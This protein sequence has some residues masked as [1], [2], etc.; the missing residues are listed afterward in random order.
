MSTAPCRPILVVD[1]EEVV[2]ELLTRAFG[3]KGLRV[4]AVT[5]GAQAISLLSTE[6]FAA[7]LSDKNLPDVSGIEVLRAARKE[8]PFCACIMMTGYTTAESVLEML[9][10]GAADYIEKPF[11]DLGILLHRV[12]AAIA[13]CQA[14]LERSL[15]SEALEEVRA[16]LLQ[17]GQESFR[18]KTQRQ[19]LESLVELRVEE[20]TAALRARIAE[21]EQALQQAHSLIQGP[22]GRA[23]Q[24]AQPTTPAID[25]AHAL[26]Q[27]RRPGEGSGR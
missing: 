7:V 8:Q 9:R 14:E 5:R 24:P 1:D 17:Q 3:R 19:M 20:E 25:P 13:H 18:E 10:L 6:P 22:N 12:Q 23:E 26:E 16:A 27:R 15:L 21:L 11:P 4:V 2:V